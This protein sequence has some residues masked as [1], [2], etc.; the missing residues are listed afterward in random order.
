MWQRTIPKSLRDHHNLA[1]RIESADR[2]AVWRLSSYQVQGVVHLYKVA[3]KKQL[4]RS[5]YIVECKS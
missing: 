1:N 4:L 5:T 2:A 3:N